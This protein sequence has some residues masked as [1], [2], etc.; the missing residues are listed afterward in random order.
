MMKRSPL[1]V[2]LLLCSGVALADDVLNQAEALIARQQAQAAVD[3]L[4]PLEDDRAGDPAYDY[5]L[6][7][8]WLESGD[9]SRAVFAF[10]RCLAVQPDNGPCRVQMARTHLALGETANARAE[11]ETIQAYNPPPAVRDMVSKY[12]GVVSTREKQEKFLRT[13]FAVASIGHDSNINGAPD[14]LQAYAIPGLGTPSSINVPLSEGSVFY[15]G[16][17]GGGFQLRNTPTVTTFGDISGTD[18]SYAGSNKSDFSYQTIDGNLGAAA[19]L[20]TGSVVGKLGVQAM[21]L[22][23]NHYRDVIGLTGQYQI[24]LGMTGQLATFL[25][26]NQLRYDTQGTR[27]ADRYTGGLAWSQTFEAAMSPVVYA[28]LYTGQERAKKAIEKRSSQ[29]FTGIRA[30]GSLDLAPALKINTG[31]NYETRKY[32]APYHVVFFPEARDESEIGLNLGLSWRIRPGISLQPGYSF[33]KENSNIKQFD[34]DR[35]MF[36]VDLRYDM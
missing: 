12:L 17:A 1:C 5:L 26:G 20:S 36:T 14:S 25:Q 6:G 22:G 16:Q 8:A 11:L 9:A 13:A 18:R 10:E 19:K 34:Y 29:D 3:L 7:Q 32:K 27:D 2:A 24:D 33:I 30:G 31:I 15:G 35:H 21:W 4:A 23:G 28:S